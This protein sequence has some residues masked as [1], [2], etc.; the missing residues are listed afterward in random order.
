MDSLQ[1]GT[2]DSGFGIRSDAAAASVSRP[3]DTRS[4]GRVIVEHV[5]PEIDGGRFPIK[6][7]VGEHVTVSADV[8][9]DGHDLV[10]GAVKYRH[11]P[12]GPPAASI[13]AG[14]PAA[15]PALPASN[16]NK[17]GPLAPREPPPPE[18]RTPRPAQWRGA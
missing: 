3:D 18:P 11:V 8:F 10:A 9:A 12:A 14:P 6:R 5:W 1:S 7:T 17:P 15:G 4:L 16:A 2:R 13:S